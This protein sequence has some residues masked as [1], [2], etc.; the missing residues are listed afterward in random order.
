MDETGWQLCS[1]G[2]FDVRGVEPLDSATIRS[3]L[4]GDSKKCLYRLSFVT[5]EYFCQ[6]N[7]RK[8]LLQ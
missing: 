5:D 1:A 4:V 3:T 7:N 2:G 6:K 8:N